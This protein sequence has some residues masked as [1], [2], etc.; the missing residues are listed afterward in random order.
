MD[1]NRIRPLTAAAVVKS[2]EHFAAW[3]QRRDSPNDRA[4]VRAAE[5]SGLLW[6]AGGLLS[7]TDA[8]KAL[9][10]AGRPPALAA[11]PKD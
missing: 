5:T 2:P 8:G 11:M 1:A 10:R 7:L 4:I 9:R 6:K 3:W